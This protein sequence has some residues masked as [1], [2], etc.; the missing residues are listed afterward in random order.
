MGT[1]FDLPLINEGTVKACLD[2][3]ERWFVSKETQPEPIAHNTV[4]YRD[5][6][7]GQFSLI[8]NPLHPSGPR[9]GSQTRT[10]V[11]TGD[12][13]P[14]QHRSGA[15][16][17]GLA[18]P[19]GL[20]PDGHSRGPLRVE[21]RGHGPP[22]DKGHR[23]ALQ[24][25]YQHR[26]VFQTTDAALWTTLADHFPVWTQVIEVAK[27]WV[28]M[29]KT[30]QEQLMNVLLVTAAQDVDYA[31]TVDDETFTMSGTWSRPPTSRLG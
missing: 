24:L 28:F 4:A 11:Q 17:G 7:V 9:G 23:E 14:A 1:G 19:L 22:E 6:V 2:I 20:C 5:V 3:Y 25:L 30:L 18:P 8:V 12:G 29:T 15:D 13:H 27:C 21:R 10:A 16:R 26:L 31:L